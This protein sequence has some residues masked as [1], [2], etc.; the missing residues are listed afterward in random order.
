MPH[1][2]GSDLPW[3]PMGSRQTRVQRSEAPGGH[4]TDE[5]HVYCGHLY[6]SFSSLVGVLLCC[7]P[8]AE[9]TIKLQDVRKN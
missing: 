5:A 4:D 1:A 7:N 3:L 2:P 9:L 8:K 6:L